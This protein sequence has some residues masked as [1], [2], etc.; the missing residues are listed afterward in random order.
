MNE[1][2]I[3]GW[4]YSRPILDDR[5]MSLTQLP[6][7]VR[8]L[9]LDVLELCSAFFENQ[10]AKY[11]LEVRTA[12]DDAGLR[13][14]NIAVDG[15]DISIEDDTVRN[16]HLEAT[17]QWFHVAH[18]VGSQAIRVNSGGAADAPPDQLQRIAEGYQEL[19]EMGEREGVPVL[20]E[21]HGGASTNPANIGYFLDFVGTKWFGSCPDSGN[22]PDRTWEEGIRIMAPHAQSTHIKVSMYSDDGWQ[23]A[24]GRDGVDR[25]NDLISF[26]AVLLTSGYTGPLCIE[27]GVS[28]DDLDASALG[29]V[30][31]IKQ[32]TSTL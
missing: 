11:L 15:P 24:Q 19:A 23:E 31:Y 16:V 29:A 20:I 22:F 26:L 6:G 1:F 17:K 12:I 30:A 27:Q 8:G 14:P 9:G 28:D 5:T 2:G 3:A 18:A 7:A 4:H 21:N 13:I 10:S 32:L 25:S